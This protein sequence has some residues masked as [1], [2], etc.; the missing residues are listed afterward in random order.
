MMR[1]L[2]CGFFLAAAFATSARAHDPRIPL[3]VGEAGAEEKVA[4]FAAA[5]ASEAPLAQALAAASEVPARDRIHAALLA[6]PDYAAAA[7]GYAASGDNVEAWRAFLAGE[8][9]DS[10]WARAHATYFLGRA[11][12]A[13]DDLEGAA[14]ALEAVRGPLRDGTPWTDEATLYLATA[15]A[16]L[17]ELGR[18]EQAAAARARRLLASLV[19]GEGRASRYPEVPERVRHGARWLLRELAGEGGGPLLELARR[20]R[21]VERMLRRGGADAEARKRQKGIV[22]ELDRL[23]ALLR[24][25]ESSGGS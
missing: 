17:P 22:D 25:R 13:R 20:M 5:A 18:D 11:L 19:P 8:H 12:L 6:L 10:V 24:E 2:L 9:A 1:S 15:Y 23:I 3:L 14:E 21:T 16:R 4:A 7:A